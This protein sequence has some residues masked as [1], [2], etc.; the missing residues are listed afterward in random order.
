MAVK[1]AHVIHCGSHAQSTRA[2][3]GDWTPRPIYSLT[4]LGY[5]MFTGFLIMKKAVDAIKAWL[6]RQ[7]RQGSPAVAASV[8]S[9]AMHV[10]VG[11]TRRPTSH[12]T[13][14]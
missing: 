9:M 10:G 2:L 3:D 12:D 13:H 14:A 1:A 5:G 7:S 8:C 6:R 4:R 11:A